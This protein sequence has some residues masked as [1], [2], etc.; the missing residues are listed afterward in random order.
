MSSL[1]A[2]QA[3]GY[4][5]PPEYFE[6]GAYK[7]QSKNQFY[8]SQDV[9]SKS[10]S[11]SKNNNNKNKRNSA[12]VGHN[13]YLQR[14]VVRFELP[15]KGICEGCHQSIGRG[16]RYNAEKSNAGKYFTTPIYQFDMKCRNCQ[17][18]WIIR[19]NPQERGFDYVKG[20][21]IQAGQET[22]LAMGDSVLS[23]HATSRTIDHEDDIDDFVLLRQLES[24]AHGKR[25]TLTEMEELQRLQKLNETSTLLDSDNNALIRKVFRKDRK[26][27][28]QRLHDGKSKGWRQGM[29]LLSKDTAEDIL[30]SKE[31]TYGRP[32]EN[33]R[34]RLLQVRSSSIFSSSSGHMS[35]KRKRKSPRRRDSDVEPPPSPIPSSC[36]SGA[37]GDVPTS[38]KAALDVLTVIVKPKRSIQVGPGKGGGKVSL[39]TKTA[40]KPT[41]EQSSS[42]SAMMA[43]YDSSSSSSDE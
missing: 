23:G 39:T 20:I 28:R 33:E 4:Y 10:S 29:E 36:H 9:R 31:A 30:T 25:R 12:S 41:I 19:T 38:T 43:A 3:D 18:L 5:L 22:N 37:I 11:S 34:K 1:A 15:Y 32:K 17:H 35:D 6:G 14:G 40:T 26:D 27:K 13:Q 7:K 8:A 24:A 42:L 2:I 16:T 21:Q